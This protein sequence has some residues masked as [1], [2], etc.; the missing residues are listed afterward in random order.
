MR[1]GLQ[2]TS[3]AAA[4]L[5]CAFAGPG[6]PV[7]AGFSLDAD[8]AALMGRFPRAE[9]E[10]TGAD[11]RIISLRDGPS[12]FRKVIARASGRYAIHLSPADVAGGV[13]YVEAELRDGTLSAL[14]LSFEKPSRAG[15]TGSFPAEFE[16]RH[17]ACAVVL[18]QLRKEHG[19]PSGSR[20]S[21]EERLLKHTYLWATGSSHL[22]LVCG[23]YAGRRAVFAMEVIISRI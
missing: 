18:A 13:Y 17:P 23:N 5:A 3:I 10:F 11:G 12:E 14:R 15:A 6:A 7:Y 2:Y 8:P 22:E 19:E 1:C 4:L 16:R 20:K 21:A 9:H